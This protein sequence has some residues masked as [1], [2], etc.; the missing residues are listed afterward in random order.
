[1]NENKRPFSK[2][3]D[4]S[5]MTISLP[6]KPDFIPIGILESVNNTI[7]FW[8]EKCKAESK[9]GK[10][11]GKEIILNMEVNEDGKKWF[12]LEICGYFA[13]MILNENIDVIIPPEREEF[14]LKEAFKHIT[15][16]YLL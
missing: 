11:Q 8:L 10:Y 15:E 16:N 2:V 14:Y 1:M 6:I 4:N 5:H 12:T 9:Y 13:D 3:Y 7:D